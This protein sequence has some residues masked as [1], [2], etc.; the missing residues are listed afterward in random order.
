MLDVRVER[1]IHVLDWRAVR[2]QQPPRTEREDAPE[3]SQVGGEVAASPP[4][5]DDG[6]SGDDEIAAEED[7]LLFVEESYVIGSVSGRMDHSKP[8]LPGV[9]DVAVGDGAPRDGPPRVALRPGKF[10]ERR[11]RPPRRNRR[12]T[13][14]VVDVRVRD[15]Y[16][17]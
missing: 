6:R 13:G 7:A 17:D 12:R 8:A 4:R 16:G 3:R 11:D 5:D 2:G 14:G 9:D 15:D 10:V 1:R